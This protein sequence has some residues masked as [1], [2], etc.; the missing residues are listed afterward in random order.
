MLDLAILFR[1]LQIYS[2]SAHNLCFGQT[3]HEDHDFFGDVYGRAEGWYDSIVERIIGLGHESEINLISLMEEVLGE[4]KDLPLGS[5][6]EYYKGIMSLL[7]K[8][9]DY[10]EKV[11]KAKGISQGTLQLVGGIADQI[12]VLQYKIKRRM[13]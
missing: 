10:C 5:N 7:N 9:N 2:H 11:C 6:Q 13:K 4:L 3:F 8:S 1:A 12:E